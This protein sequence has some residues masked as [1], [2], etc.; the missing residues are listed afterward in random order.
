MGV[1]PLETLATGIV[2]SVMG[3]SATV[4]TADDVTPVSITGVWQTWLTEDALS[5]AQL[6]RREPKRVFA[7]RLSESAALPRGTIIE[8]PEDPGTSI[9]RWRIDGVER[10]DA[11]LM[12]YIVVPAPDANNQ[13][14][15]L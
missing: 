11:D 7:V 14:A 6:Q 2:F 9:K 1:G 15:D 13:V 3:V 12:R 4:H 5:G 8:A 10:Q